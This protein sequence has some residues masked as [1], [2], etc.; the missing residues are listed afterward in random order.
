MRDVSFKQKHL[1]CGWFDIRKR[2]SFYPIRANKQTNKLQP[3]SRLLCLSDGLFE[4]MADSQSPYQECRTLALSILRGC[5][6]PSTLH[7]SPRL[8]CHPAAIPGSNLPL[9]CWRSH[10][11]EVADFIPELPDIL[12]FSGC[13]PRSYAWAL[14]VGSTQEVAVAAVQHFPSERLKLLIWSGCGFKHPAF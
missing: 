12:H 6:L 8:H 14:R 5:G 3:V 4:A 2:Q 10:P 9:R 1:N 13:R 7:P 11:A